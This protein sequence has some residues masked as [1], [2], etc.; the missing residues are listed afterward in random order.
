[1]TAYEGYDTSS[2]SSLLAFVCGA[3]VGASAALLFAPMRGEEMRAS[4]GDAARQSRDRLRQ[5]G[6][7]GR[8]WANEGIDRA[9]EVGR[10]AMNRATEAV[11]QAKS[12]LGQETT[13]AQ[14]AAERARGTANRGIESA[15]STLKD[16]GDE[17]SDRLKRDREQWS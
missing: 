17:A 13:G 11:D 9:S 8:E 3:I 4:L 16:V 1:M 14:D 5:Y 10:S 2:N 6:E 12:A 7:T 15:R